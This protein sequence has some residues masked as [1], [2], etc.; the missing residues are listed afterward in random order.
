MPAAHGVAYR[1][2]YQPPETARRLI[3]I[4]GLERLKALPGVESLFLHHPPG[5]EIDARDGTRSYLFA[6]VGSATDYAGVLAVE[7]FMRNEIA[8]VYDHA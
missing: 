7:E 3:S 6:V 2:F 8:A 1:F 5:S 4:D